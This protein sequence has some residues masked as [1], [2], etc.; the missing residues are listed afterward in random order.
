MVIS[1]QQQWLPGQ[2]AD[3]ESAVDAGDPTPALPSDDDLSA[4]LD[5]L[6]RASRYLKKVRS[7]LDEPV[8]ARIDGAA[9]DLAACDLGGITDI[10]AAMAAWVEY[11]RA[12]RGARLRAD[13]RE[14]CAEVGI[15]PAVL[16]RDPLELYLAPVTVLIDVDRDLADLAFARIRQGRCRADGAAIVAARNEVVCDL[17]GES[18]DPEAFFAQLRGAWV[19]AGGDAWVE[20]I[21]VLPE[22][23]LLRQPP[24]FRK[25]PTAKKFVP[26]PRAQF[27]Y[28]LWRLRRD[29]CL[30]ADGWRLTLG[31]ATGGSTRDKSRVLWLEDGRGGGQYH[32]TLRFVKEGS[33]A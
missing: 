2:P 18:W 21:D 5:A 19:R 11:E 32:L 28:D 29:R 14:A 20:L 6:T 26:Y 15:R 12:T 4:G 17:E 1:T 8:P 10:A 22:L 33:H 31:T 16:S 30:A 23:A 24:S 13:L 3:E 27:A 25:D 7:L 9:T